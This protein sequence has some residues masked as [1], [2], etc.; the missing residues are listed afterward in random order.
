MNLSERTAG[1]WTRLVPPRPEEATP[2]PDLD[3]GA[4]GAT[5]FT[6]LLASWAPQETTEEVEEE[7]EEE[8]VVV[9]VVEV[10]EEEEQALVPTKTLNSPSSIR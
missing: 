8:E 10:E 3:L 9:E 2:C 5:L 7:V 1:R 6:P 4:G